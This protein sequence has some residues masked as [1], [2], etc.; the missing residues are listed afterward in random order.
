MD[1]RVGKVD[2]IFAVRFDEGD[3]FLEELTRLV[4]REK[5]DNGWF[6]VMGGLR[7]VDLVTGPRE[8]VMPPEPV[9]RS[10]SGAYETLGCGSV[11]RDENGEAKIHLHAALGH[12]GETLTG[13][14]R[15]NSKVYLVL[16]LLLMEISGFTARRPWFAEGGFNRVTFAD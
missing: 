11:Y 8:A 12:H 1:Y 4:H 16:E 7:Q 6:Q 5:I 2:R 9:W 10:M 3:D 14:L 13:C 15:K